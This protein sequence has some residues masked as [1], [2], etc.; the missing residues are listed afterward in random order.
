ML[1]T[2]HPVRFDRLTDNGRTKPLR[3]SVVTEDNVEHDAVMKVSA[4]Q[5]C[6]VEGL[7]NEML[8]SLLAAD[9]GLPVCEP[10]FVPLDKEFIASIGD[11]GLALRLSNSCP[12]AFASKHAGNQWRR[13]LVS[14]KL[15]AG[16]HDLALEILAFDAFAANSDRSPLNSNMLVRD[17]A[18]RIIDHESAFGIRL[19]LFPRCEP[20]VIGNLG[21]LRRY[22]ESGEHIFSKL[23]AN[24]DNLDFDA[25]RKK[26]EDLSDVRLTQYDACLPEE[27]DSARPFLIDAVTH[28]K[29]VRDSIGLCLQELKRVLS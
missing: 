27:W 18:W 2:A 10:Y 19:R 6:N 11:A 23:L 26:W 21:M 16:R 17:D 1:R 4:G 29:R 28:I 22:G 20:W 7:A 25:L 24:N 14:D 15:S 8:G 12:V 13:W 5:E 3:V 9:L